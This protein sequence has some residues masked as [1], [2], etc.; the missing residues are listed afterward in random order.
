MPDP[1]RRRAKIVCTL[2]PASD[3]S[4]RIEEMARAGM[5][6]ARLNMSHGTHEHALLIVRRVKS[7]AKKLNHPVSLLLDLQAAA[8]LEVDVCQ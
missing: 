7:L 3:S 4:Q 5:N 8:R 2:G 6:L 1:V